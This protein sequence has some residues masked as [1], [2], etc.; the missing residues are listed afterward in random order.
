MNKTKGVVVVLLIGASLLSTGCLSLRR[1]LVDT[2][3]YVGAEFLLD[4]A[5]M[6]DLF[7]D[8]PGANG[9]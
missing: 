2:A 5:N 4:N 7:P 8:G 3:I 9:G 1:I 6:F